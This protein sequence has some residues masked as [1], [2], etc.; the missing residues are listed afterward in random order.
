MSFVPDCPPKRTSR[1]AADMDNDE[2]HRD[3]TALA[4]LRGSG[5]RGVGTETA[6]QQPAG[7]AAGHQPLPDGTSGITAE[8]ERILP[9]NIFNAYGKSPT[10][11]FGL[12]LIDGVASSPN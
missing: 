6:R 12:T 11:N 3:A 4:A 5:Q 2:V 9:R 8:I 10:S 1:T 7:L